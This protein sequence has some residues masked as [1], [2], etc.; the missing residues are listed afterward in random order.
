MVL[1]RR[2]LGFLSPEK[3]Q[4]ILNEFKSR[5]G[6]FTDRASGR[7]IDF[8]E[9]TDQEAKE[10]IM[11]DFS[12]FM[13]GKIPAKSISGK[14]LQWF[15]GILDYIKAL[16]NKGSLKDQLFREVYKGKFKKAI[17]PQEKMGAAAEYREVEGLNQQQVND[18]VQDIAARMFQIVF[19]TKRSLF[20]PEEVTAKQVIDD[21]KARYTQMGYFK[22][23]SDKTFDE[24]IDKTKDYLRAFNI[25]FDTD[26]NIG[27]NDEGANAKD[28]AA[29]T[30]SVNFK[31][32][33]PY[34][35]KLLV[36][37]LIKTG[38]V[39]QQNVLNP[40]I[41]SPDKSGSSVKGFMLVPF[42]QSFNVLMNKLNNTLDKDDF[43]RKL[44][45]LAKENSDYIALFTR[46]GGDF[47]SG[48]IDFTKY[49]DHDWRLFTSFY[50]VFTKQLP[51]G[52]TQYFDGGQVYSGS[53]NQSRAIDQIAKEWTEG[54]KELANKKDSIVQF[55]P[56]G[57]VYKVDKT[58][59]KYKSIDIS[60]PSGMVD[61]LEKIG[62]IFPLSTYN[63]LRGKQ[64]T[65][66]ADAVSGIKV[67]LDKSNVLV[68]MKSKD[69]Q[70]D[71][72]GN[73]NTIA[74]LYVKSENPTVET[75]F[76]NNAGKQQQ[77]FTDSNAPSVFE[78]IFNSVENL[79]ELKK[80]M[81]QLNDVFSTTSQI[82]KPGGLFFDENGDRTD[83]EL[84]VQYILGDKDK[85]DNEG[86]TIAELS[87][88]KRM[89]IEIN[90]NLKGSY[91]II[92]P[93]DGSTEWMMNVGNQVEYKDFK[94]GKSADKVHEIFQG[95]LKDEIGLAKDAANR[96]KLKNV[97]N[98]A[99]ELRFFKEL[100]S[101]KVLDDA[102]K[103]IVNKEATADD[104]NKFIADNAEAINKSVDDFINSTANRTFDSLK[105]NG[106]I[107]LN[108][109]GSYSYKGLDSNFAKNNGI[110]MNRMSEEQIKTLLTFTNTNFSINNI[111][112]HKFLF[113]DPYQFKITD[114]N[115]KVILDE[116][117]RI[118]SFL[119]PR[120]IT[121]TFDEMN[122]WYNDEYNSAGI[123]DLTKNDY[124]Y[125]EFKN[126]AK[127]FTAKDVEIVGSLS[128]RFPAYAK[129]NEAD[130]ASW[131]SP[132]AYREVKLK[133]GQW[134]EE[135][136]RFH[137]WQMSYTRQNIPGYVYT[138]EALRK[139]DEKVVSFPVPKY[140]IEVLKP[141]VT[142]NKFQK[143]DINLVLDKFSQMPIYY[144]AVQGTMLQ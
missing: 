43:V 91:Y 36:S 8:N 4:A 41:V 22:K 32:S 128:S 95:Y 140:V 54:M 137:Q 86:T 44:H 28:Y 68:S 18:F 85:T 96:K 89:S 39:N 105:Y 46:L 88:G 119:S 97:G 126:Y 55:D 144:Q 81:P 133:N 136:E 99:S 66:F 69:K 102:N 64:L 11:D 65:Q 6:S 109:N 129:T 20:S 138:N 25:E 29:E 40:E 124:G 104:V 42:G 63:R 9:A 56:I 106:E 80:R 58:S 27:I 135:A 52:I 118:K 33:S 21:I 60:T 79:K 1:L 62:I 10:R 113:G 111:E 71:I 35:V 100:L 112:Y 143:N 142:G 115:G 84:K 75:S 82:L 19:K 34:A 87:R 76:F 83:A 2:G 23:I 117:K 48:K 141:I 108:R 26:G 12:E 122:N 13:D 47:A 14:I 130:A 53:A 17:F 116:T 7:T 31:K 70:L 16:V 37:T 51:D 98:K 103:L 107:V 3:R 121:L 123:I 72:T 114:K 93:G 49:E 132:T 125:H 77:A 120:R 59:D 61:F 5:K 73:V 90:Q 94:D 57:K 92:M 134:S 74:D 30:F 78:S 45:N 24:L 15:R 101:G 139:Q 67:G 127:T 110:D 131:I 50:Q 38:K